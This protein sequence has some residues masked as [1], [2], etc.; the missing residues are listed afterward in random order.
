MRLVFVSES[1]LW[2]GSARVFTTVAHALASRGHEVTIATPGNSELMRIATRSAARTI[3]LGEVDERVR[4]KDLLA[5]LEER[6][7]DAVFVHTDTE[8]LM[9]ARA[10]KKLGRGTLVRR[11]PAGGA[12]GDTRLR[13]QAE[14][15]WSTRYVYTTESPPSGHAAPSRA[16]TPVRVELGVSLPERPQPPSADGYAVLVCLATREAVR[17]ATNVVRAAALLAQQHPDLRL[18][19]IGTAAADPDLQVLA[20]ALGLARR[21]DWLTHRHQTAGAFEGAAVGWVIG[22]GDDAA[23]GVLQLMAHGLVPLAERA[24]VAGRYVSHGIH[25]ILMAHL[26]PPTMAAET[27]VLLSDAERRRTMGEAGRGRVEREFTLREMI[28]GFESL[29]RSPRER[30]PAR[31]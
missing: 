25:G 11:V 10:L 9:A 1:G 14:K 28:A 30:T 19:V 6:G 15:V 4:W 18:R 20:S 3:E 2:M 21:V 8:H 23:L 24:S 31:V 16:L 17:R 13:R 26:D 22:D 29:A 12:I 7:H 5:V 27:T